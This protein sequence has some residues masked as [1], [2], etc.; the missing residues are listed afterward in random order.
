VP[1]IVVVDPSDEALLRGFWEAEQAAIR[2]DRAYPVMRT[3]DA[4]RQTVQTPS[5]YQERL[6][7]AALADGV[8][9]GG[10][11]TSMPLQDT[12]TW[13]S[14]RST[15]GRSTAGRGS[16]PACTPPRSSGSRRPGGPR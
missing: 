7:M 4:L 12:C 6:L 16:G 2:A 15:S 13:A 1:D 11:D 9:I 10:V 5:P 3:W 14:S 8:V